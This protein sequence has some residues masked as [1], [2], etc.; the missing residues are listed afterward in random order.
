MPSSYDHRTYP[1]K[2][3]R[4]E[5]GVCRWCNVTMLRP[6]GT[7]NKRRTFCSQ[8]CVAQ[9]K[10]RADPRLMRTFIFKRDHGICAECGVVEDTLSGKWQADH[11]EPLFTAFGDLSYWEPDN[12][13]TLCVPCHKVKSADDMRRLGF[14]T[15]M[16]GPYRPTLQALL[17]GV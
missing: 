7:I 10:L 11:I 2:Y 3:R 17:A 4:P 8:T 6:D 9:Y 16:S 13:Q 12:L 14:V 15:K 1:L 5:K